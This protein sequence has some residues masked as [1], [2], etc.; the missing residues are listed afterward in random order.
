MKE[1][2]L[3]IVLLS[4][5]AVGP[6]NAAPAQAD[7]DLTINGTGINQEE[8]LKS[9]YRQISEFFGSVEIDSESFVKEAILIKDEIWQNTDFRGEGLFEF[10]EGVWAVAGMDG[11]DR[12]FEAVFVFPA[13]FVA[14]VASKER[15]VGVSEFTA[16]PR[17]VSYQSEGQDSFGEPY[18]SSWSFSMPPG[19][20]KFIDYHIWH[21]EDLEGFG[22]RVERN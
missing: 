14:E 5:I 1:A 4:A 19:L 21:V 16:G 8:A 12:A 7:Q 9:A 3:L 6:Q 2:A 15:N 17:E 11:T 10:F 18:S 13:S 20:V 22:W